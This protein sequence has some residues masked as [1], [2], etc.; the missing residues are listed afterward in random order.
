MAPFG[1]LG[2]TLSNLQ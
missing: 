2:L 1:S